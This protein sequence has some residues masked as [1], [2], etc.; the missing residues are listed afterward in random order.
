MFESV[1]SFD[2]TKQIFT[3]KELDYD[4]EINTSTESSS[5]N[6]FKDE[7]E[8]LKER[9]KNLESK[10]NYCEYE[11]FKS[12]QSSTKLNLSLSSNVTDYNST[13]QNSMVQNEGDIYPYTAF[14][15]DKMFPANLGNIIKS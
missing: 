15:I 13:I 9:I 8:R 11:N 10:L 12:Q 6:E 7:I 14:T 4:F 1:K 2:Q 3:N 5:V